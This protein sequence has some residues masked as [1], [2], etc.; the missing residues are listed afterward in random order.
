MLDQVLA[1]VEHVLDNII[2][3]KICIDSMQ[4]GLMKGKETTDVIFIVQ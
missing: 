1:I 2:K 4:F 3:D